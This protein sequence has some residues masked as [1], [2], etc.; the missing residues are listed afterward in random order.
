MKLQ[1]PNIAPIAPALLVTYR[2]A[3]LAALLGCLYESHQAA[4]Y[5][6]DAAQSAEDVHAQAAEVVSAIGALKKVRHG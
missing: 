5:A 2:V 3:I 6:E 1:L 4:K